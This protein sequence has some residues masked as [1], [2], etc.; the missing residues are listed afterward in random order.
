MSRH[1]RGGRE[2]RE[3]LR[4]ALPESQ[5]QSGSSASPAH[6]SNREVARLLGATIIQRAS[7]NRLGDDPDLEGGIA[8]SVGGGSPLPLGLRRD[9]E[10]AFHADLGEVRIHDDRAADT[11]SAQLQARAFTTGPDIF[12]REGLYDPSSSAGR[13][14]LG[15]EIT[16]V[17]QQRNQAGIGGL[18]HGAARVSDPTDASEMAAQR[19]GEQVAAGR[20]VS[21][22]P[23]SRVWAGTGSHIQRA[24]DRKPAAR[25][26][27]REP[28]EVEDLRPALLLEQR[29]DDDLSSWVITGFPV[30]SAF[31]MTTGGIEALLAPIQKRLEEDV[32][33]PV[34]KRR[35]PDD[36]WRRLLVIM[37]YGDCQGSPEL[38][39]T[40]RRNRAYVV[41]TFFPEDA[42]YLFRGA[43]LDT[44]LASNRDRTGRAVNRAVKI[45]EI[46]VPSDRLS[47][48]ADEDLER[49]KEQRAEDVKRARSRLPEVVGDLRT[50]WPDTF[51]NKDQRKTV[52]GL[53]E[54]LAEGGNDEYFSAVD[55]RRLALYVGQSFTPGVHVESEPAVLARSARQEAAEALASAGDDL[56]RFLRELIWLDHRISAGVGALQ[57][58]YSKGS[59]YDTEI[60]RIHRW[61]WFQAGTEG[62]LMSHYVTRDRLQS[63]V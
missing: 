48:R 22:V 50:W 4:E 16:H 21:D 45:F 13:A 20:S 27:P 24:A 39:E 17:L 6:V 59:G 19:A 58:V 61:M 38:N 42:V 33:V 3:R 52:T 28:G 49:R 15:H 54:V 40:L 56:D 46:Q 36:A 11:F 62:S 10:Q 35:Q 31:P 57:A 60:A 55:I 8:A 14:L 18:V 26:P 2:P 34:E 12:F 5:E 51:P 25:C 9:M 53:L 7:G 41:S 32:R 1:G 43:E 44:Y 47:K 29:I 37:G 63:P 30:G 23:A